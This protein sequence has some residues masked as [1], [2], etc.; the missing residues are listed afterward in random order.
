MRKTILI[1]L[2]VVAAAL[3]CAGLLWAKQYYDQRYLSSDYWAR[4]PIDYQVVPRQIKAD[5]GEDAGLGVEY[6]LKAYDNNGKAKSVE[7]IVWSEGGRQLPKPGDYLSV[8]AS[9]TL[10]TGW[11]RTTPAQVPMPA[12]KALGK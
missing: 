2:A 10:V 8:K 12:L 11:S 7:F 9:A 4:V 1:V 5:N 3:L 6:R